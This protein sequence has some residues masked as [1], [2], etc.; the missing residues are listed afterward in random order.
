MSVYAEFGAEWDVPDR[1][2]PFSKSRNDATNGSFVFDLYTNIDIKLYLYIYI[3][4]VAI[5]S[6]IW[7]QTIFI[8]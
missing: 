3:F 8:P 2:I 5:F 4:E 7:F 1:K 6:Q